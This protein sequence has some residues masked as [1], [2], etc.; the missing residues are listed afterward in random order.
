MRAEKVGRDTMLSRIVQMV[1]AAQRSRAPIQRL[2][3]QVAGWF[4]PAVIVTAVAAFAAWSIFGPEPRFAFG[5]VAAVSV[6]IIACPCALGLATPM[7]IMV[8]VGRGAQA[9]V[10]IKNAEA[11]ERMEKVDTLVVDKTGTLTEGKPKVVAVVPVQGFDEPEVLRLA[12]SVEGERH[13]LALAS[14]LRRRSASS[15]SPMFL[16]DSRPGRAP[17]AWSTGIDWLWAAPRSCKNRH[18]NRRPGTGPSGSGRR[19]D[20]DLPRRRRQG[21]GGDAIADPVKHD[22]TRSALSRKASGGYAHRRQQDTAL[23]VARQLGI[24]EVEAEV[25]PDRRAR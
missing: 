21:C 18:C 9:G 14:L 5:L 3:D 11:L 6:L 23:A 19:R 13:P 25:L 7:S 17:S 8:G 10:L 22:M 20:R 12:A 15:I 4:V 24:N 2:A 16:V 1:A